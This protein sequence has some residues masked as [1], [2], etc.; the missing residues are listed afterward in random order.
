MLLPETFTSAGLATVTTLSDLL[1]DSAR[2][3]VSAT[4]TF[5]ELT[6]VSETL[7]LFGLLL[8]SAR[9]GASTTATFCELASVFDDLALSGLLLGSARA[10][11]STT[12]TFCALASASDT[13]ASA[14]L[15]SAPEAL[16]SA[17][18]VPDPTGLLSFSD[19]VSVAVASVAA[20]RGFS[21][22]FTSAAESF[23]PSAA[24]PGESIERLSNPCTRSRMTS[25]AL[26]R[27]ISPGRIIDT[28]LPSGVATSTR[29]SV[30]CTRAPLS[31]TVMLNVV[32]LT[33]AAK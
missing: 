17:F 15:A 2:A 12:A 6:L 8:T 5:C 22:A 26:T 25:A 23:S 27:P 29:P 3:G 9:A 1:L 7:A 21:S 14:P 18:D 4:A 20:S 32:P 19:L 24:R 10:G 33:T 13:L 30:T 28:A 16:V 31:S 11:A